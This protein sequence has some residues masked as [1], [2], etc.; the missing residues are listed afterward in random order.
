MMPG[1][2]GPTLVEE[3]RRRN[4]R[5]RV[6]FMSGHSDEI[7]RD[8]LLD[9]TTPFLAKPSTPTQLAQKVRATLDAE[10]G[11]SSS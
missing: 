3:L 5:L 8:G 4:P 2:L 9:P 11:N 1:M 10:R 6:L 7:I